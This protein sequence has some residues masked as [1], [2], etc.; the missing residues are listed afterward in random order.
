[1]YTIL[2]NF[3]LGTFYSVYSIVPSFLHYNVYNKETSKIEG[4]IW[5]ETVWYEATNFE[6]EVDNIEIVNVDGE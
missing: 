1:M 2:F 5:P 6:H 3:C 4:Y